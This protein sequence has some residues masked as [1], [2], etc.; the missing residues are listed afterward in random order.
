MAFV[1]LFR[2][3][4]KHWCKSCFEFIIEARI[5]LEPTPKQ[6]MLS[7]CCF[8]LKNWAYFLR[9]TATIIKITF[10]GIMAFHRFLCFLRTYPNRFESGSSDDITFG[11]SRISQ[12]QPLLG[13]RYWSWYFVDGPLPTLVTILDSVSLFSN[14]FIPS[15]DILVIPNKSLDDKTPRSSNAVTTIISFLFNSPI[16]WLLDAFACD[17]FNFV[18]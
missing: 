12:K 5:W 14:F 13:K 4:M 10:L 17:N 1:Q 3:L 8:S 16:N 15:L 18:S 7:Q 11:S 6:G 9:R 2:P